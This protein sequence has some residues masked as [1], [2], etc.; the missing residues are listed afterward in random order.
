MAKDNNIYTNFNK[1]IDKEKRKDVLDVVGEG[2]YLNDEHHLVSLLK[3]YNITN[4]GFLPSNVDIS[5]L[6]KEVKDANIKN[7]SFIRSENG[8]Y[9]V[10]Y[11]GKKMM[12]K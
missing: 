8:S 5:K 4:T 12:V 7:V 10:A 1:F 6:K 9:M 11:M 2:E 3:K